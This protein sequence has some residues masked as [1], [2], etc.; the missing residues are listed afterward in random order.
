MNQYHV[1]PPQRPHITHSSVSFPSSCCEL[2]RV[3][4]SSD[5]LEHYVQHLIKELTEEAHVAADGSLFVQQL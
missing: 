1:N 5:A 3:A 4:V 2:L